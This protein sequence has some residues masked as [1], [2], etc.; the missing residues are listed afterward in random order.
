MKISDISKQELNETYEEGKD[1]LYIS[2]SSESIMSTF[3]VSSISVPLR[4][5]FDFL[6]DIEKSGLDPERKKKAF[7]IISDINRM[8]SEIINEKELER[9]LFGAVK[10]AK[11][12]ITSKLV[13]I[14]RR[15]ESETSRL[16]SEKMQQLMKEG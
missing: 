8:M 14:S 2:V 11:A 15:V 4:S 5:A 10:V 7:R 12:M 9:E 16:F 1:S 6:D 13:E 3:N